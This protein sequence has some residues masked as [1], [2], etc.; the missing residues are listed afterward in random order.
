VTGGYMVVMAISAVSF[1]IEYDRIR[2]QASFVQ[3]P[4]CSLCGFMKHIILIRSYSCP[5]KALHL[6]W[7]LKK[8]PQRSPVLQLHN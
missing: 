1:V 6:L 3:Y 4:I 2:A 5:P 8:T 7:E